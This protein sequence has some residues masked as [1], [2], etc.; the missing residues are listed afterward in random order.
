M[1]LWL[2]YTKKMIPAAQA[3]QWDGRGG[4]IFPEKLSEFRNFPAHYFAAA[5]LS[6]GRL[7]IGYL[8][9]SL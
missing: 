7:M 9:Q 4:E 8:R 2:T 5:S 1:L 6:N 3:M